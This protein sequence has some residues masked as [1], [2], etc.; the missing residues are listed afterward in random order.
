M[1][2]TEASTYNLM[3]EIGK[4][5]TAAP[6]VQLDSLGNGI[7]DL[8]QLRDCDSQEDFLTALREGVRSR[9]SHTLRKPPLAGVAVP[10]RTASLLVTLLF[11][12]H[13]VVL[14]LESQFTQLH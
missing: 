4:C 9:Y 13:R 5:V 8:V 3:K 6:G 10:Q 7:Q 14:L 11:V 12:F 1:G 2:A